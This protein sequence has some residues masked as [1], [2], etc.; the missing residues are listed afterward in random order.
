VRALGLRFGEQVEAGR[1]PFRIRGESYQPAAAV[2]TFYSYYDQHAE[3]V[4]LNLE[5]SDVPNPAV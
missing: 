4:E 5:P 3:L 1:I 2:R